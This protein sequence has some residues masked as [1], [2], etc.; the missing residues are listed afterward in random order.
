MRKS[1]VV[2]AVYLFLFFVG[3]GTQ[4]SFA[5]CSNELDTHGSSCRDSGD[6]GNPCNSIIGVNPVDAV[7]P[8]GHPPFL[9]MPS[10]FSAATPM[11]SASIPFAWRNVR[12][13]LTSRKVS[14]R[15]CDRVSPLDTKKAAAARGR[16]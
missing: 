7:N 4:P 16:A 14:A 9:R 1:V 10:R 6:C 15:R 8:L 11:P 3:V 12:G 5:G 2:Y 13:V